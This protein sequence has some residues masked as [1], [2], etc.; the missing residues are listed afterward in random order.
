[1]CLYLLL[2]GCAFYVNP[3]EIPAAPD[4]AKAPE[5]YTPQVEAEYRIEVGD[6]L[7]IRSYYDPQL[8]QD[9]TVRPDGMISLLLMG[10]VKVA[11]MTPSELDRVITEHYSKVV[12]SPEVVVVVASTA[13]MSVYLSGEVAKPSE[14][15]LNG[16]VSVL[17]AISIAGGLLPTA[18]MHQVLL[19]RKKADGGTLVYKMDL[20][21][22]LINKESDIYLQRHDVVYVPKTAIANV[23]LFVD[24]YINQIIPRSIQLTYGW[25]ETTTNGAST[26]T[27]SP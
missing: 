5:L 12:D 10:D 21:K 15:R 18:N 25:L 3:E 26:V 7:A 22:V 1:M 16:S 4:R 17:Q 9:I 27:I 24:Q 20:G 6:K 11:G 13:G 2:G 8:N 14:E 19:L 23:D